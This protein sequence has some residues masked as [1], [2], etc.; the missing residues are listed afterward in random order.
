MAGTRNSPQTQT[1]TQYQGRSYVT[2]ALPTA[3]HV[4]VVSHARLMTLM[5]CCKDS[6]HHAGV[7]SRKESFLVVI[8]RGS[9]LLKKIHGGSSLLTSSPMLP[10][11]DQ[12]GEHAHVVALSVSS[13]P[14]S[15]FPSCTEATVG[16]ETKEMTSH[17]AI[18]I[19]QSVKKKDSKSNPPLPLI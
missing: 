19:A 11:Q 9:I 2:H 14:A 17:A 3:S 16:T 10:E 12:V 18:S 4:L 7:I 15:C 13:V 5:S 1:Q 8:R 6:R